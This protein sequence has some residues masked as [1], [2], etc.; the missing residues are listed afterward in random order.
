MSISSIN[1]SC[2]GFGFV[3]VVV[4]FENIC[5]DD[6]RLIEREGGGSWTGL[7][8]VDGSGGGGRGCCGSSSIMLLNYGGCGSG[9]MKTL[10]DGVCGS[11]D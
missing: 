10:N 1:C 8:L 11:G 3:F 5:G 4:A 2:L 7:K 6:R 9:E